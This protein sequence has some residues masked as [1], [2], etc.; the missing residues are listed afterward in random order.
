[1]ASLLVELAKADPS[2]ATI[3]SMQRWACEAIL[4][5]QVHAHAARLRQ[6][7]HEGG[8]TLRIAR[9]IFA[10]LFGGV[11]ADGFGRISRGYRRC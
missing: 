3:R 9:G 6:L 11:S 1:M 7:R 5:E 8:Q 4:P 10:L 2:G